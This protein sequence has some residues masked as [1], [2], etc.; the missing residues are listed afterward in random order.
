MVVAL[1]GGENVQ[2]SSKWVGCFICNDGNIGFD[3]YIG[4]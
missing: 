2:K 1:M 3:E 4:T